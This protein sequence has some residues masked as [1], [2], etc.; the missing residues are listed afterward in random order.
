MVEYAQEPVSASD[1]DRI[2]SGIDLID[3]G[4][5]GLMPR[6][7]YLV[8]GPS[9]VGKSIVGMQFLTRGLEHQ[10][11]GILITDQKPE[12]VLAQARAIGFPIDEAVKRQQLTI[13]NPSERY[14][15]LVESPADV[16]AIV[17]E[18]SDYIRKIDAKRLVIDPVFTLV[19]TSY[20]AHF[21]VALT[22]SLTN[23]L[24]DLP[25]TTLLIAPSEE[26]AE[27]TPI[28]RALE[29]NAFGIVSLANDATTGGRIMSLPKLR[30]ADSSNLSAHYRILNGR[31]LINYSG[32]G[33]AVNDVTKPWDDSAQTNRNVL[34][35]GAQSDTIARVREALGSDYQIQAEPDLQRG[36][37]RAK[38]E[39]PGLVLVTPSR[40]AGSV[41]AVLELAR[42]SHS[43]VAFLSPNGNRQSDRVLYLKAGA[44]DFITEPF[45]AAEL[46]AR[47]EALIRRSGRRLKTRDSRISR[48]T[49]DELSALMAAPDTNPRKKRN[50]I[51]SN[52]G[53]RLSFA[54]EFN[55]RIQRSIE[56]VSKFDTP[57]ALYWMK[58]DKED[59]ELSRSLAKLCRQ[60]DIL[61]HNRDGEFV[62]IL[63]GTDQ[64][65][66]RGF[67]QRLDEKLGNLGSRVKRGF[68]LHQPGDT[69]PGFAERALDT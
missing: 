13:L 27:L 62:A 68:R 59:A 50:V 24:E 57:F 15:D 52:G 33:E 66:V 41:A 6:H 19:N 44:D 45:S 67:E 31:G 23:A 51:E 63:T 36:V 69:T 1:S 5:G 11:T 32:D 26:R 9:G 7:L 46:R 37:E 4:A 25:T 43:S 30:Y 29:Q 58:S 12:A 20:S 3:Y 60:E 17:E 18:L 21:A 48:I 16:M 49:P 22:Q 64:T 61:C 10:E 56:T 39:R 55:E 2:I 35:I 53:K 14:F 47:T 40:S 8:Q 34:L 42:D 54:P 38:S 28:L 65:G